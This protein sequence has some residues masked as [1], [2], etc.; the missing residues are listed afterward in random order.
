[1][2]FCLLLLSALTLFSVG[3]G[4]SG[5][6]VEYVQGVVTLNGSPLEGATVSFSPKGN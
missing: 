4:E 5:P 2:H 3:C 6:V 1:M